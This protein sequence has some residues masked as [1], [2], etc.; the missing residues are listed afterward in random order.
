MGDRTVTVNSIAQELQ[1]VTE[2]LHQVNST[3]G[4]L[5]FSLLGSIFLGLV[6]LAWSVPNNIV[7][8]SATIL[9]GVFYGF[10]L[11]CTHDMAHQTLTGWQWFDNIIPRLMSWPMLWPYSVYAQLHRLHHSWNGIDLRD[12]ERLQWTWQEYQQ[13][14]PLMRWYVR[15]QWLGD[16][17]ILGGIGLIIKTFIKGVRFQNT[18]ANMRRQIMLDV[19]GM[20]F[21]HSIMLMLAIFQGEIL[22]YLLFW[23]ILERVI[24]IIAQTRDHL[25]HYALWGKF[26]SHQLTQ[27]YA[28]RNIQTSSLVGWLMGGLDYHAVHHTFPNIP[29]N[30]LPEAFARIQNVLQKHNLPL[31]KLEL[32]YLKSTYWLSCHPSLIG[33]VD[34]SD[35]TNRH[36][37]IPVITGGRGQEAGG[38]TVSL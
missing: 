34:S 30:Q 16:I 26:T 3:I 9:A 38:D 27:L 22:R 1:Q 28:C 4:L 10:W 23:L 20:L 12:P 18:V 33:E 19:M 7:F 17:F 15:H 24:G 35:T 5:R 31:M 29:F 21:V 6:I 11:I 37:M 25:E 36:R 8:V 13:A 2:D 32:G 14:H